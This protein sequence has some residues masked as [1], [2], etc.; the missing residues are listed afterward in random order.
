MRDPQDAPDEW[1]MEV[2]RLLDADGTELI[3]FRNQDGEEW[4]EEVDGWE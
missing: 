4:I 2:R 3:L 1:R